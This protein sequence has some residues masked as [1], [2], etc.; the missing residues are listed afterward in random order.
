MLSTE[1]GRRDLR[2]SPSGANFDAQ[3]DFDI[4]FT[5]ARPNRQTLN[6]INPNNS[7]TKNFFGIEKR[8]EGHRPKRVLAT[9]RQS[10]PYLR[11]KRAF[12]VRETSV[13][14]STNGVTCH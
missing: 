7:S 9:L 5:V 3:E 13:V 10:E 6:N 1:F 2:R 14:L 11:R 8:H 12:K 4:C